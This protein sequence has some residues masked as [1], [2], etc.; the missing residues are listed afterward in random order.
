[1]K[2]TNV[3]LFEYARSIYHSP[4]HKIHKLAD[5]FETATFSFK[6]LFL[7]VAHSELNQ[8]EMVWT[9]IKRAVASKNMQFQLG[10]VEQLTQEQ[11]MRVTPEQFRKYY[12]HARKEE[13]K[14]RLM[15][16]LSDS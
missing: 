9:L 13:D 16:R 7:S 4:K 5:K 11:V 8:I 15:N 12:S 6:I 1:M 3:Q 10:I 2:K 14:Y